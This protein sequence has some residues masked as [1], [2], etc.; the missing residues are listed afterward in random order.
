MPWS[1]P[2]PPSRISFVSPHLLH[3]SESHILILIFPTILILMSWSSPSP[4]SRLS[5]LG[6]HLL[7][8]SKYSYLGPYLTKHPNY[9][10]LVLT[11]PPSRCSKLSPLLS[12]H[13]D[14]PTLVLP[15]APTCF[16]FWVLV[17]DMVTEFYG[18]RV[19]TLYSSSANPNI[20][21]RLHLNTK[22]MIP[23]RDSYTIIWK[24]TLT[25]KT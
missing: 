24:H 8:S 4:P 2:T 25:V 3:N 6:P 14:S 22:C 1:S 21:S 18:M 13:L 9:H 12:L 15:P 19:C 17:V 11:N 16:L 23:Q 20:L 5:C 7:Q 10:S